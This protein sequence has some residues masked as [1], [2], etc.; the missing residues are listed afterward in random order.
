[1]KTNLH[2]YVNIPDVY[3]GELNT[4][5]FGDFM[6]DGG[7]IPNRYNAITK[8]LADKYHL[9]RYDYEYIAIWIL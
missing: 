8:P 5:D 9:N 2:L 3:K 6:G 7:F 4:L 1:M